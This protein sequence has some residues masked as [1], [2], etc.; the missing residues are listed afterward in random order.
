MSDLNGDDSGFRDN[1]YW[2]FTDIQTRVLN[3]FQWAARY[4][5]ESA[6]ED[7]E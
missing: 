1:F 7:F 2:K 5:G 4:R 6:R 3:R